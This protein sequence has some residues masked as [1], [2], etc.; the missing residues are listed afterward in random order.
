VHR[1]VRISTVNAVKFLALY[2]GHC[3]R[4]ILAR[5]K[6]VLQGHGEVRFSHS[7][8]LADSRTLNL[9]PNQTL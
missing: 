7:T 6:T 1:H 2:I 3:F 8:F 9:K 5:D 4:D